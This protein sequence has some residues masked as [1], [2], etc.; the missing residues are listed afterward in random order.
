MLALVVVSLLWAFSFGLIKT[1]LAGIDPHFV[2]FLRLFLSFLA[3]LPFLRLRNLPRGLALRLMLTGMVQYGVMYITYLSAFRFL[4]SYEVALFTIFTPLYVTL[5]HNALTRKVYRLYIFTTLLTVLGTGIVQ[6]FT[7]LRSDMLNG[8]FLVQISN[9]CFA[10]GQVYYRH[11]MSAH[12]TLKDHHIFGLLYLGAFLTPALSFLLLGDWKAVTLSLPQ[13]LTILYLGI[14]SSGL[15][16]F[17][18]NY[19][20][21][22]VNPGALAIFNDLKIPLAVAVSLLIFGES[23]NWVSLSIGGGIVLIALI[24][25][26]LGRKAKLNASLSQLAE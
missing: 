12:S 14:I 9:L 26:E 25:N 10:A 11:V 17:L 16:F 13:T 23:A 24:I 22:R 21:R 3:F 2:A 15:A 18:W 7:P 8:F 5:I 6:G 19:G 20:S 4:K 1:S